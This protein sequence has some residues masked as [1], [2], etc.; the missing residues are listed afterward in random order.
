MASDFLLMIDGIKG[1]SKQDKHKDE[2]E[3]ESFSWG[4]SQQGSFGS[5][6]GGGAGKVV[7]QD[8]HFTSRV[9]KHSPLVA[10]ACATG[11]HIKK[12]QLTV[13]KAGDK[14]QEYYKVIIEDILVSSYQTGGSEGSNALPVDQFALNFSKIE[15]DYAP[16]KE[17]GNLDSPVVFKYDVKATK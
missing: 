15:F 2:I 13:R 12:G 6:G 1:E 10:K 11:Q 7:F 4:A 17:D 14:Q 9:G 8:V 16:Q 5:G 3:I